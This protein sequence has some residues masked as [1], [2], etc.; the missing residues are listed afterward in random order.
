MDHV[1]EPPAELPEVLLPTG[2]EDVDGPV[3]LVA[4]AVEVAAERPGQQRRVLLRIVPAPDRHQAAAL[5][6]EVGELAEDA[7]D[8]ERRHM[9]AVRVVAGAGLAQESAEVV[10]RLRVAQDQRV[11]EAGAAQELGVLRIPALKRAQVAQDELCE[12]PA[13]M[14]AVGN[15][16]E[17]RSPHRGERE[18]AQAHLPVRVA[19]RDRAHAD[20]HQQ[21]EQVGH[22]VKGRHDR[23]LH[24][25]VEPELPVRQ[26]L[27]K[28]RAEG[29]HG[30]AVVGRLWAEDE[31][32][33]P[34]LLQ[35]ADVLL[36]PER[37]L[38]EGSAMVPDN[39]DPHG[40]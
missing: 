13:P 9:D 1:R 35:A 39:G 2:P 21:L 5:P 16:G 19:Q 6:A 28:R 15:T 20:A 26:A 31:R 10:A 36:E 25:E 12:L 24:L 30:E 4:R 3:A 18:G 34:E 22:L 38:A 33:V 14:A 23:G 7:V 17:D 11:G 32:L 8:R 40:R 27:A 37:A 29:R